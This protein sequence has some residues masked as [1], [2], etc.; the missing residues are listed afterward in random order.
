M[1]ICIYSKV[2]YPSLGGIESFVFLLA[3]EFT[4]LG[5]SITVFTDISLPDY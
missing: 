5:H 2:F 1:K 4:K 3:R